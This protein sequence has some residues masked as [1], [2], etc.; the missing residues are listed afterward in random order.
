M[1][2]NVSE[3]YY[4]LEMVEMTDT[5]PSYPSFKVG[6]TH[7]VDFPTFE[8]A[9]TYME[10]HSK[11][12]KLYRSRITQYPLIE[13]KGKR[14]AQ[15]L[16]DENGE[17][18]DCI[19]VQKI[20]T[21][22]ETHFFG[23]PCDKQRFQ[24]GDIAE[25]LDGN[26][27]K[28]VFVVNGI[29]SPEQCWNI[30]KAKGSNYD[31]DYTADTYTILHN[32]EGRITY[33]TTTALMKPRFAITDEM[34]IKME[35]R[36]IAMIESTLDGT[37]PTMKM[38]RILD[39]KDESTAREHR[40]YG[41]GE[42]P[43]Y[44]LYQAEGGKWGL[45]D[46]SGNRLPAEFK[47]GDNDCFSRVPWEVVTFNP[48]EGFELLSWYD[49]CEVWFNFTFDNPHYPAEYAEYLWER[50]KNDVQHY[51]DLIYELIP[52]D[53]HWLIDIILKEEELGEKE[54]EDFDRAV[55]EL[56]S[57]YPKLLKPAITNPML[58]PVMRNPEIDKDVKIALWQTKVALDYD[59]LKYFDKIPEEI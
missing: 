55:D 1:N 23:R 22:E 46:G 15:W 3:F 38:V 33:A 14:G 49:P 17:S 7:I 47:R 6:P 59:I 29:L 43:P 57:K 32:D 11:E 24:H 5:A 39:D 50:S 52:S 18:V 27:V 20:G 13:N 48:E 44:S 28:L 4:R 58:E 30:Y 41:F 34:K 25:L 51:R 35:R 16:F 21:P 9:T 54:D 45:I 19:T 31:L 56:L 12:R 42:N 10:K 36:Y 53:N 26:E 8:S 40:A 2:T 37:N